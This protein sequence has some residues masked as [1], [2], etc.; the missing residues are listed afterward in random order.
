MSA[1]FK[2]VVTLDN[3]IS[4]GGREVRAGWGKRLSAEGVSGPGDMVEKGRMERLGFVLL[5]LPPAAH[6]ARMSILFT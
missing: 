6:I 5:L 4:A 1:G 3:S 2:D